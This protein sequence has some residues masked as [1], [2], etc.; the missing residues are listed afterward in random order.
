MGATDSRTRILTLLP[1]ACQVRGALLVDS[2]LRLAFNI[3]VSLKTRQTLTGGCLVSFIANC[4]S[5]T[6]RWV[7]RINDFWP[8]S[9]G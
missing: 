2:A 5:P 6:R 3:G 9:G 4:I 1:N 8:P 7:A